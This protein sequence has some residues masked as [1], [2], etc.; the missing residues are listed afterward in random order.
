MVQIAPVNGAGASGKNQSFKA[1]YRLRKTD[2]YSSVFSFR[3]TVRGRYFVFHYRLTGESARLGL[4]IGKKLARHA[5][6]RNLLKRMAREHFRQLR[7][8]LPRYD[9]VVRLSA[10]PIGAT[11]AELNDDMASLFRRLGR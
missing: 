9:I 7:E 1:V 2:E 4:V 11:R 5:V 3:K 10:K 6:L 8:R